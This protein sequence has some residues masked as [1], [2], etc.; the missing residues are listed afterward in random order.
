M[1]FV[2]SKSLLLYYSDPFKRLIYFKS[3]TTT[4]FNF[5]INIYTIH[6]TLFIEQF[7]LVQYDK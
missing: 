2:N 3:K 5:Y 4:I 1:Y 7:I 6:N